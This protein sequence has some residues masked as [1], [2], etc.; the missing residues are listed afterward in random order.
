MIHP[1]LAKKKFGFLAPNSYVLDLLNEVL[2][3]QFG[4][5]AAKI[6]EV[7][8]RGR[9]NYLPTQPT[10]GAWVRTGLSWQILFLTSSF[11]L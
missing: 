3:I 9:K 4:Q 6:S 7:K 10:P 5:G 8:V 2:K 11:N 1:I